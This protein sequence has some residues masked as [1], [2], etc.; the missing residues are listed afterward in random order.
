MELKQGFQIG[1]RGHALHTGKYVVRY[2]AVADLLT[3]GAAPQPLGIVG[4]N[5]NNMALSGLAMSFDTFEP[6]GIGSGIFP[7]S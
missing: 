7:R 4:W 6:L 1:N 2:N 5:L 3:A